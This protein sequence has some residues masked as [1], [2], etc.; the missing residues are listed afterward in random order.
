MPAHI[1]SVTN[2][3]PAAATTTLPAEKPKSTEKPAT[4][5]TPSQDSVKISDAGSAASQAQSAQKS[6]GD[7]DHDGDTKWFGNTYSRI[8][9]KAFR[10]ISRST[11]AMSGANERSTSTVRETDRTI[12]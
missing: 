8:L 6:T 2:S 11:F 3:V 4:N 10:A 1:N 12:S 5:R 7:A 9:P